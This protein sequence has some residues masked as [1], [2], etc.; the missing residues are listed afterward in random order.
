MQLFGRPFKP[1]FWPSVVALPAFLIMLGLGFW[2][3]DR[4]AE[5]EALIGKLEARWSEA[6]VP[7]PERFDDLDAWEYRRVLLKGHFLHEQ[8]MPFPGKTYKG[9]VGAWIAT[10][11]VLDDGREVI[12]HRGWVPERYIPRATRREGLPEGEV[13]VEGIVRRGGW[14][15]WESM[16][17]D[18][19]PTQN[20]W[21]YFDVPAMAA[22]AGL[23]N[24]ITDI[25]V[26]Q[27]GEEATGLMPI[28][29]DLKVDLP[30]DHLQYAITWFAL[31]LTLAVI[32]VVFHL[33]G[34][35]RRGNGAP[36]GG[37]GRA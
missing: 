5:K 9:T 21:L 10:P 29:L 2:Q 4:L 26:S 7:L 6:A 11:F 37:R 17:P 27:L 24:A 33:R 14:T 32:Y 34:D 28:G 22:A 20:Y 31:A 19:S 16:R 25:Y 36:G 30:N 13:T 23:G 1:R 18:N 15:G 8:E 3:L 12:V 35:G